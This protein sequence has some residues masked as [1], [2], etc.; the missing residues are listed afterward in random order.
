MQCPR[1]GTPV[2]DGARFCPNC[3]AELTPG[4]APPPAA[5]AGGP[6]AQQPVPIPPPPQSGAAPYGKVSPAPIQAP[7]SYPPP[8]VTAQR[9]RQQQAA[10]AVPVAAA[11]P[12]RRGGGALWRFLFMALLF[13]LGVAL[14]VI[15][16]MA[17]AEGGKP[18]EVTGTPVPTIATGEAGGA[19]VVTMTATVAA[20][21]TE[22]LTATAEPTS[23]PIITASTPIT[24]IEIGNLAPSFAVKDLAGNTVSLAD[25]R[26]KVV[27]LTFWDA[28]GDP[29]AVQELKALK[30]TGKPNLVILAVNNVNSEAQVS[31]FANLHGI[32]FTMIMW[33]EGKIQTGVY[34]VS[35]LPTTFFLD[36][37]GI[38]REI[39]TGVL[40]KAELE[41]I[42]DPLLAEP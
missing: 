9:G 1:C 36:K 17:L 38:I 21:V 42:V 7:P 41:A 37:K 40:P 5:R 31:G 16:G 35:D 11:E 33:D 26:G 15:L 24:G 32:D 22:P 27:V 29:A 12:R 28:L 18:G 19:P 3:R 23:T 8:A 25:M 14:G 39:K 4:G 2:R 34:A 6:P 10:P 13:G 20:T 30:D